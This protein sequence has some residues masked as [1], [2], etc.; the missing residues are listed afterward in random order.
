MSAPPLLGPAALRGDLPAALAEADEVAGAHRAWRAAYALTA[1]GRYGE[2]LARLDAVGGDEPLLSAAAAGLRAS[3][4]RQVNLHVRAQDLDAQAVARLDGV[5]GADAAAVRAG[6]RIGMVADGVGLGIAQP[7]LAR[8]LADATA[9]VDAC[10][11]WRQSIRLAWVRGEVAATIAA[12]PRAAG[13]FSDGLRRAR[14]HGAL[15]HEVKTLG[16]LAA[17]TSALGDAAT[18]AA[19]ARDAAQA[20]ARLGARPLEWPALLVLSDATRALGDDAAAARHRCAAADV[21]GDIIGSLPL[22]LRDEALARHPASELL[23]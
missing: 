13:A 7:D 10:S 5:P 16:F 12:W 21:L 1:L 9:A 3:L 20:A 14:R 6:L 23:G 18:A 4:L 8:R 2:A 17:T 15:R 19:Q 11:D 22:P